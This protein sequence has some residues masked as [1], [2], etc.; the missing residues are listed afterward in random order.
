MHAMSSI[1]SGRK[2]MQPHLIPLPKF[3][4]RNQSIQQQIKC[5]STS[6]S[7]FSSSFGID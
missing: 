4:H 3:Q 1:I 6:N 7:N 2:D 5:N